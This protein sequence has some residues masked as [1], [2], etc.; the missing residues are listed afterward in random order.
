MHPCRSELAPGGVPTKVVND[1]A[2]CL[3]PRGALAF[4]ASALAPTGETFVQVESESGR[5]GIQ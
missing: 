3:I 5:L 1:N 4:F 2:G